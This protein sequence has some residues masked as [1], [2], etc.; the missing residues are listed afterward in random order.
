MGE[1]NEAALD[2]DTMR[3][4]SLMV[5]ERVLGR[6]HTDTTYYIRYRG[7]IYADAEKFAKCME[8]WVYA[9]KLQRANPEH[10]YHLTISN[11]LSFCDL[12]NFLL[13]STLVSYSFVPVGF[14]PVPNLTSQK[15]GYLITLM[16]FCILKGFIS[17]MI[18]PSLS[19]G[20]SDFSS[21]EMPHRKDSSTTAVGAQV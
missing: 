9:L 15:F 8:L 11:L 18:L 17:C 21:S 19:S 1:L 3:M 5:R 10:H 14:I 2:L 20:M 13:V 4:L 16:L 12:F 7:A 6:N